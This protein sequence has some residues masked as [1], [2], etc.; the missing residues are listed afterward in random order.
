M[1]LLLTVIGKTAKLLLF[2]R[3]LPY[4]FMAFKVEVLSLQWPL[5]LLGQRANLCEW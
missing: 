4:S 2:N 1:E 3:N 5:L